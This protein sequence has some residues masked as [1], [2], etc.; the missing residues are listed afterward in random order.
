[1]LVVQLIQAV[2][3][4]LGVIFIILGVMVKSYPV[5]MTIT[6]LVLYVLAN[7]IFGLLDPAMLLQGVIIKI[8]VVVALIK[9]VQAALA[10]QREMSAPLYEPE[11]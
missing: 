1:V 7:A 2:P 5:P 3:V 8:I 10:Y 9:A 4:G 6:G 11:P